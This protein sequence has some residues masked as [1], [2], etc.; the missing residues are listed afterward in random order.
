M[1]HRDILLALACLLGVS[2]LSFL[3]VTALLSFCG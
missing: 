1:P 3:A 2:L